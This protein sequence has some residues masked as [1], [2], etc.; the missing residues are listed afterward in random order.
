MSVKKDLSAE[1][2]YY[3]ASQWQLM[4]GKFRHHKLAIIGAS[5]L[6]VLYLLFVRRRE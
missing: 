6:L 3:L 1:E 4:W 5:V 2:R